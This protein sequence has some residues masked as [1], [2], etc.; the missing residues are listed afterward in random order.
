[1]VPHDTLGTHDFRPLSYHVKALRLAALTG[2]DSGH[3]STNP[4]M[5]KME[6]LVDAIANLPDDWHG[7]GTVGRNV[8]SAIV[9]HAPALG[10]IQHV[11]RDGIGKERPCYSHIYRKATGCSPLTPVRVFPA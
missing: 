1:V 7:A 4:E 11:S 6:Q 5:K 3:M 2:V 8:L 9:R 10:T